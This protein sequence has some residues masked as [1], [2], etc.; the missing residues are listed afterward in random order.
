VGGSLNRKG[1]LEFKDN[2]QGK[3]NHHHGRGIMT[4]LPT[5]GDK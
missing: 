4:C 1:E 5:E 2:H 3:K